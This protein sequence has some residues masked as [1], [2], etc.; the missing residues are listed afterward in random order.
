MTTLKHIAEVANVSTT[1]V[2]RVLNQDPSLSVPDETR[3]RIMA[4]AEEMKYRIPRHRKGKTSIEGKSVKIGLILTLS[5]NQESADPYFLSIRQGIEVEAALLGIHTVSLIRIGTDD[6]WKTH[7]AAMDGI[8]VIGGLNQPLKQFKHVVYVDY[9]PS[10][11]T[12]DS[13]VID[14]RRSV[15][16]VVEHLTALGHTKIGYIGGGRKAGKDERHEYF[17]Q[18]MKEKGLFNSK[19]VFIRDWSAEDGQESMRQAIAMKDRPTAFFVGSDPLAIGALS[20]LNEEG[21]RVPEDIALIGFDDIP[22]ASFTHPPLSTVKIQPAVMG[23][24]ALK[25]L[26]DQFA[27]RDVPVEVLVQAQ[28]IIR[29]T[30]G[31]SLS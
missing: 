27:G 24:L 3:R 14:F 10:D 8:I 1:T 15:R 5:E 4:I 29:K 2:S 9:S 26:I 28:L 22:I 6:G 11:G 12:S 25:L 17:E 13:I 18:Y 31:A 19:Y 21:I 20:V 16:A 7:A 30:C 23:K